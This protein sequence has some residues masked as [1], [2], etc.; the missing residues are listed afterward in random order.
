MRRGLV[1]TGAAAAALLAL[2]GWR[3]SLVPCTHDEI[4]SAAA[5][6]GAPFGVSVPGA[7]PGE[8]WHAEYLDSGLARLLADVG[9]RGVA[10]SLVPPDFAAHVPAAPGGGVQR[11]D[12]WYRVETSRRWP[13]WW[14]GGGMSW[15]Q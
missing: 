1:W 8:E 3:G 6:H 2:P 13:W 5:L 7:E 15:R 4:L 9:M 11:A 10:P 14:P 12:A